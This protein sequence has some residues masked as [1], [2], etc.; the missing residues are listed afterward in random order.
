[1]LF[2]SALASLYTSLLD[3]APAPTAVELAAEPGFAALLEDLNTP[4][5]I[6]ELH[7]L[8][9]QL[10]KAQAPQRGQLAARM[11][12]LGGLLGILQ[13]DAREWLQGGAAE[14]AA[15]VDEPRIEALVEERA[16]AKQAR[17]FQRAD[18]IREELAAAGVLLED[19]P[20]GTRWR[21]ASG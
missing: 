8:A 11:R 21:R 16:Q 14:G 1:M 18:A 2:R 12:A 7:A 9:R 3:T 10:N 15:S 17:D 19:G 4:L 6:S 20:G 13:Q 5:A